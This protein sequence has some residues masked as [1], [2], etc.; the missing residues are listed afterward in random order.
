MNKD[1]VGRKFEIPDSII[2]FSN[3]FKHNFRVEDRT[4]ALFVS[5]LL[6]STLD[7]DREF[8]HS[9]LVKRRAKWIYISH[10]GLVP[11]N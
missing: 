4:L 10:L 6:N 1:K 5:G 7:T 9:T 2:Q 8:D 11:K 3:F